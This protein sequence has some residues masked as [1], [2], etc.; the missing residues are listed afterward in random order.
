MAK[1]AKFNAFDAST[2]K[3]V[4][5]KVQLIKKWNLTSRPSP[6]LCISN[7]IGISQPLSINLQRADYEPMLNLPMNSNENF[8][9]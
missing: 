8:R 7:E 9:R 3:L 4:F 5:V 6:A 2:S 1:S